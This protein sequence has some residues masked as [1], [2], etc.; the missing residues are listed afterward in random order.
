VSRKYDVGVFPPDAVCG[1]WRAYLRD[2]SPEW[3][4]CMVMRV[5]ACDGKEAKKLAIT[6]AKEIQSQIERTF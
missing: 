2:Y 6:E 3:P 1:S 5:E 4:G